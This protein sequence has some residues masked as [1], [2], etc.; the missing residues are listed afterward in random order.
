MP[1]SMPKKDRERLQQLARRARDVRLLR[2][3][4]ALLDLDAG[5]SP[6][7]VAR[8]YLVTRSTVYNWIKQAIRPAAS[9]TAGAQRFATPPA[10]AGPEPT[11]NSAASGRFPDIAR[12]ITLGQVKP[13]GL[14]QPGL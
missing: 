6:G 14:R 3:A 2:R 4:Q 13:V 7:V 8:R 12:L 9:V 5:E 10:T 1:L 11:R